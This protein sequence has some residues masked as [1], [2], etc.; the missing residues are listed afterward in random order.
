MKSVGDGIRVPNCN[1]QTIMVVAT[2]NRLPA[3]DSALLQQQC[4]AKT[5]ELGCPDSTQRRDILRVKTSAL[6]KP[7]PD[8][9]LEELAE[10]THGFVAADLCGLLSK[11]LMSALG[12]G[13]RQQALL[14]MP[15]LQEEHFKLALQ[16]VAPSAIS[17]V[18]VQKP[19][20]TFEDIAGLDDVVQHVKAAVLLPLS[21]PS[22]F[23]RLGVSAPSGVLIHGPPGCGKTMMAEAICNA[24]A[25]N[26]IH[27]SAPTLISKVVGESEQ[28]MVQ[29]F[30]Q[31]RSAAPCVLF[32]DQ[33]EALATRRQSSDQH[34]SRL[35]SCLL[36]ELD[37]VGKEQSSKRRVMVLATATRMNM[38]DS[39]VLRAGRIE[40][41]IAI[42]AI[43]KEATLAVLNMYVSRMPVNKEGLEE[44]LHD[45]ALRCGNMS[46]ADLF[47]ICHEAAMSTLRENLDAKLIEHAALEASR[48]RWQSKQSS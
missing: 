10:A 6:P 11:A 32:I 8:K 9:L 35:L 31:A 7:L 29:I 18:M 42:P 20:T 5:L 23:T 27:V 13:Q 47:G 34:S 24:L 43:T 38:L 15:E 39:A 37:G 28:A 33:I 2:T 44:F 45:F 19:S 41:H 22:V 36:T 26:F 25:T 14:Q 17:S 46:A 1:V 3:V 16:N 40:L 12:P 30:T 21:S 4:F 48:G